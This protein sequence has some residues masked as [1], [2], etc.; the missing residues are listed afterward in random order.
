SSFVLAPDVE[1]AFEVNPE[2]AAPAYLAGL[3][4][5]GVN[6]I[7][8]GVQSLDE[9]TLRRL[10]RGH[11]AA[12]GRAAWRA[13]QG[14]GFDNVNVD[15]LFGA[16]EISAQD[17]SAD[18]RQVLE[19][20][21]AHVSLYG[22]D[23]EPG[24]LFGRDLAV[25]AWARAHRD[26]QAALYLAATR[27]LTEQGYV[28]YEVS[29]FALPERQGRQNL[30]VWEPGNY[31]GVG[32]GA[33]SHVD[34]LRWSNERRLPAYLRRLQAG[35][36]PVAHQE[37]LTAVQQANEH[38]LLSLRQASGLA[39]AQ[40]EARHGQVWGAERQAMVER[41]EREH[42]AQW[43]AGVLSLTATGFLLADGITAELMV[44]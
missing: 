5:L 30:L 14:A 29:N 32:L 20:R 36:G 44:P 39:I 9:A 31:L 12:Q 13:T 21:P 34:G 24:T 17:F 18:L 16:P 8:L 11:G 22:L 27:A 42:H 1:I 26:E 23:I 15:L 25:L 6:R 4:S 35:E 38:L 41:L 28:H 2:D 10:G 43:D 3:A 7:S 37:R 19:W 33:H 40:W